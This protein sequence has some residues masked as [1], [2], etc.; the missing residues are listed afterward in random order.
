M[1]TAKIGS[2]IFFRSE[3]AEPLE[4][5]LLAPIHAFLTAFVIETHIVVLLLGKLYVENELMMLG[6]LFVFKKWEPLDVLLNA[7]FLLLLKMIALE[8]TLVQ[9]NLIRVQLLLLES[10][11]DFWLSL[12]IFCKKTRW[13]LSVHFLFCVLNNNCGIWRL[14]IFVFNDERFMVWEVIC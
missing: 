9:E 5:I 11:L 13:K 4:I 6:M 10:L 3:I 2:N 7:V 12:L 8:I 14:V 1:S